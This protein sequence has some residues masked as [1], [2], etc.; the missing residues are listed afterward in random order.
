MNALPSLEQ[1]AL[2]LG[3]EVSGGQVLAPGPN[4]SPVDRSLSVKIEPNAPDGFL[5]NTF[6]AADDPIRCKDYV[7]AKLGLLPFRPGQKKTPN[8][9]GGEPYIT[10]TTTGRYVYRNSDGTPYLL[11]ERKEPGVDGKKKVFYQSHWDGE[12]WIRGAPVG[13]RILYGLPELIAAAPS[14]TV[15][16][17]EG[18]GK[19]DV[20]REK[21]FSAT[22]APEGSKAPWP[23]N[24]TPY[25]KD[26]NVVILVDSDTPG[27]IHG[28]KI[29][30]ALDG[31]V[32]SLRV[33]DLYPDH[34]VDKNGKDIK[35]WL[36]SDPAAV[37]L[38]K[39]VQAALIWEPK[40]LDTD[41]LIAE[42]ASLPTVD[43][44]RRR[45][46]EA[47]KLGIRV[48]ELDRLVAK[49]RG[50]TQEAAPAPALYAHWN[51]EPAAEPVDGNA[52]MTALVETIR[53]YVFMGKEQAIAVALW[54]IFTW[55]HDMMTHSPL[56]F[57]T[58]AEADSG[59]TTLLGVVNFL[60]RRGMTSVDA[61]G[62]ALFRS[63][64]KWSPC[65]VVDE[66]DDALKDNPDLRSVIN[67][68]WTVGSG[69][70]R[71]HSETLEPELFSTFTPKGIGMKGRALP[72]TTLSRS[73][74]ITMRPRRANYPAERV[75]DFDHLDNE[76]FAHLRS[77]MMRWVTDNTPELAA[78]KPET[79]PDF[80]N[81]RRANWRCLLGIAERVG[82]KN[83]AEKAALAIEAV[84]DTFDPSIGLQLLLAIK[85]RFA[86]EG[87]DRI[88]S[89]ALQ[90][91][92]IGD[93]TGPWASY[94]KGGKPITENAIAR[95][96]KPYEIRPRT[97]RLSADDTAK[98][99]QLAWFK[100]AFERHIPAS[101]SPR[102]APVTP[103]Q[104]SNLS[105]LYEKP[106]VTSKL[107][108]TDETSPKPLES[109]NCD[110]VTDENSP[111]A[112]QRGGRCVQCGGQP[113]GTERLCA[114]GEETVWL[115]P[116]CER[117]YVQRRAAP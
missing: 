37:E 108:V 48:T 53:R 77:Q 54:I 83:E 109:N 104:S 71:C 22:C 49:A 7:R 51:V 9:S 24:M 117:A 35:D 97:I 93:E 79:P 36:K 17:P 10:R 25:L 68:G 31:A 82:W 59:K 40:A 101:S 113:D 91:A 64:K 23:E 19:V 18:E 105:G 72:D 3:G 94:G 67:S 73:I 116:E 75:E 38:G 65:F 6:S 12:K 14:T 20:L 29:A 28:E 62:P 61:S 87:T 102:S 95:L 111:G 110:G 55:C 4:H 76:T 80:H 103:S 114:F 8:R 57:V 63:I 41:A 88:A 96:L 16:I 32:A 42:L 58:S 27:R 30:K 112:Q 90:A 86:A 5:V 70:V 44:E 46:E 81:R 2:A 74:I 33:V 107:D 56:L 52:M 92:L 21:G 89:K 85:E 34:H 100:E 43:Y 26:R 106:S 66:A 60:V 1:I 78:A 115:H 47:E 39:I 99:Y 84:R 11:V 50:E 69:V 98:G 13:P 15:F 45:K